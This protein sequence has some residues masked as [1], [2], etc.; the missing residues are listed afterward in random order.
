M[1]TFSTIVDNT[2]YITESPETIVNA[3]D[4]S[5]KELASTKTYFTEESPDVNM[6]SIYTLLIQ[7]TGRYAERY[8]SD[9]LISLNEVQN[10]LAPHSI[11]EAKRYVI[12]FGIRRDGVDHN[13]F[14]ISRLKETMIRG[15]GPCYVHPLREYRSILA[16][17]IRFTPETSTN[18]GANVTCTLKDITDDFSAMAPSDMDPDD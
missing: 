6:S 10:L 2:T 12:G 9:L 11:N 5:K 13:S 18:Y 14:I 1:Q 7:Y 15:L 17:E 4:R 8:A 16:L 3:F